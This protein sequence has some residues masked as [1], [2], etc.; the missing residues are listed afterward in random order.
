MR[1]QEEPVSEKVNVSQ[2][3][4]NSQN[5]DQDSNKQSKKRKWMFERLNPRTFGGPGSEKRG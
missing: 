5:N 4:N 2:S 1:E 3:G